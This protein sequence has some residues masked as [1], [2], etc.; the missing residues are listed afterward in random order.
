MLSGAK[1][2][3]SDGHV[4]A[5][6]AQPAGPGLTVQMEEGRMRLR[7]SWANAGRCMALRPHSTTLIG[8]FES[9]AGPLGC[10]VRAPLLHVPIAAHH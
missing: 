4:V 9:I 3:K 6:L 7:E 1:P 2:G 8:V 10:N 5:S